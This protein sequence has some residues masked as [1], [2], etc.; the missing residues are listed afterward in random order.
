MR[1]LHVDSSAR[2]EGSYSRELSR[3]FVDALRDRVPSIRLDR[4]D[5]AANTPGHFGALETAVI[6]TSEA[7]H[8][9]EMLEAIAAFDEIV[10]RLLA[11]D[12]LVIG[13]PIYSF[14]MPST[15][16]AFFDHVS[17]NGKTFIADET[18]MRGLLATRRSRSLSPP[19]APMGRG[20][21]LTVSTRSLRMHVQCSASWASPILPSSLPRA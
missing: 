17:R 13:T 19:E 16:K 15:L 10:A 20:R 1:I 2:T 14:G 6:S 18:G 7:D 3:H 21:C 8:T 9:Q 5:L 4:L 12:A 11:A